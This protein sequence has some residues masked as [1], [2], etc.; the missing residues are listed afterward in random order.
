MAG[1]S[2]SLSNSLQ[3]ASTPVPRMA[4]ERVRCFTRAALENPHSRKNGKGSTTMPK[5]VG[6]TWPIMVFMG[7]LILSFATRAHDPSHQYTD[8]FQR[9][10][11]KEGHVCCAGSDAHYL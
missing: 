6:H 10:H 8:W 3:P 5:G 7:S 1:E 2:F 9:Q 4:S 11:N